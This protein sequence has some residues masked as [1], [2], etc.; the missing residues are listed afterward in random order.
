MQERDH[1]VIPVEWDVRSLAWDGGDLVDWILGKRYSPDGTV[2][3]L[4]VCYLYR[5]DCV[6]ASRDGR[7]LAFVER[8]GTKGVIIRNGSFLREINRSY[9]HADDYDYP[10]TFLTLP[11]GSTGIAH[12]PHEYNTIEIEYAD[13]GRKAGFPG[14]FSADFFH[15]RLA[16]SED[17]RFLVSAGWIWQPFDQI[18]I[19]DLK[20]PYPESEAFIS[21]FG[22]ELTRNNVEISGAVFSGGSRLVMTTFDDGFR[23]DDNA[24]GSPYR[25]EPD[26]AY[27][28]DLETGS[29]VSQAPLSAV[30]GTLMPI[31]DYAVSFYEH[32]KIL[33]LRTG[34]IGKI[35]QDISSGNQRSS[36][37]FNS[38]VPPIASDPANLRFA[39]AS[40]RK[41]HIIHLKSGD[42]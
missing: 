39:V 10:F 3:N 13:S 14:F 24:D 21:G 8:L 28:I 37:S 32:P 22:E 38:K 12:C 29:I 18:R 31:G 25:L 7:Y 36:I 11:D 6:F 40:A 23:C 4:H 42:S 15:S 20:K 19:Y 35:W 33:D 2:T 26:R 1:I 34:E 5:F 9:Y 41:V 27:C 17:G 16:V 30:P